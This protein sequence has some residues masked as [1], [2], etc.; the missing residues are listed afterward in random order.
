M[1][2][3]VKSEVK[4][5]TLH[6]VGCRLDDSRDAAQREAEA[7]RG[8]HDALRQC[9]KKLQALAEHVKKDLD[10]GRVAGAIAEG[11][12]AV[13]K[14]VTTYVERAA[15][16]AENLA[17]TAHANHLTSMGRFDAFTRA[18]SITKR[19]FDEESA[20]AEAIRVAIERGELESD[21][22]ISQTSVRPVGVH[23]GAS[24]AEQRKA[25]EESAANTG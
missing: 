13:A 5:G 2:A 23:P 15:G 11:E 20:K 21:G 1:N 3:L 22:M 19:L 7:Y 25:E 17:L 10:E 18:T 24:I 14:L 12:L 4:A 8:A 6:E 9:A 16:V